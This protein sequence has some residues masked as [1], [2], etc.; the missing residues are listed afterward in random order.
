MIY[1]WV[2]PRTQSLKVKDVKQKLLVRIESG[3]YAPGSRFFS[4]R[5]LA[6]RFGVSYQTAHRIITELTA[7]GLLERREASGTY[8]K[9]SQNF[10]KVELIF[11]SRAKKEGSFGNYLLD[12]MRRLLSEEK[13]EYII[14]WDSPDVGL[15]AASY[16]ICWEANHAI[17]KIKN[18]STFALLLNDTPKAGLLSGRIDSA[19]TNDYAGGAC[20]AELFLKKY[21]NSSCFLV[22][23]GPEKDSRSMGR[24]SGFLSI[25]PQS[26]VIYAGEWEIPSNADFLMRRILKINPIGIFCCNDRLAEGII[27]RYKSLNLERPG[28]IGFD[29]APIAERLNL[30]TIGIPWEELVHGAC[31]IAKNRLT[32]YKGTASAQSFSPKPVMRSL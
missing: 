26:N 15:S 25:L 18:T 4:N 10:K 1:F 5:D 29:D 22:L 28:L 13:V 31:R 27:E 17:A 2:M 14:K 16:P 12:L 20:A 32:G 19:S 6:S 7:E 23:G 21:R 30:T 3:L 9:G 11:N 8:L 24:V